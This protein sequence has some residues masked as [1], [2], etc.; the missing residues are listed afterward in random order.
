MTVRARKISFY[1]PWLVGGALVLSLIAYIIC[2]SVLHASATDAVSNTPSF[3]MQTHDFGTVL[4]NS[5]NDFGFITVNSLPESFTIDRIEKS[6]GCTSVI[7]RPMVVLPGQVLK[8]RTT[9]AAAGDVEGMSSLV[10]ILAHSDAQQFELKYRLVAQ[11]QKVLNFPE[12]DG[13]IS[14]GSWSVDQLPAT[15]TLNVSRG[16]FPLQFDEIRASCSSPS[17]SPSV[18]SLD[19]NSWQ[20]S[21]LVKGMDVFGNI[22][23]PIRF[24]LFS[25]GKRLPVI[26]FIDGVCNLVG[27]P[28]QEGIELTF[29][30]SKSFKVIQ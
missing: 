6:C 16:G 22:G 11:V 9:L 5:K 20:I 15:A 7:A 17:L 3:E 8:V 1:L 23:M 4:A 25:H 30:P 18:R 19:A 2:Q 28:S 12:D 21:C 26:V 29:H 10:S 24:D 14:L 13:C 27:V